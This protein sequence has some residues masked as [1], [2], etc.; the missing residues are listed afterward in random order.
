MLDSHLQSFVDA[1]EVLRA[2]GRGSELTAVARGATMQTPWIDAATAM[3]LGDF[4]AAA[5]I[6]AQ[7]GALPDEAFARLR[8][9]G[10]LIEVRRRAAGDAELQRAL[11]FFRSVDATAYV[12][13]GEAL[14][15]RSA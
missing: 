10:S 14:L 12:R 11:A 2:L 4:Q 5:E 6:Y 7:A 1:S 3:V 13:E 9:A 8:A 15:S